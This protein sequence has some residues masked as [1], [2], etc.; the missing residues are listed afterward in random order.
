MVTVFLAATF[1]IRVTCGTSF[2][3]IKPIDVVAH[4]G[5]MG[6]DPDIVVLGRGGPDDRHGY[7]VCISHP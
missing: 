3:H 6:R 1:D 7:R 2:G 4:A 5:L